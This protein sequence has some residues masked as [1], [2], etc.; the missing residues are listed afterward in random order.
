MKLHWHNHSIVIYI[1]YKFHESPPIG[2]L[3]MAEDGKKSLK[4]WQ[5]KGNN[6]TVTD[7]TP[8]KLHV[9]NLSMVIYIQYKFHEILSNGYL[10]MAENGKNHKN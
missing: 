2:Y 9:H 1:Q 10:V 7:E 6:S 4:L 8:I 3:V 5:S